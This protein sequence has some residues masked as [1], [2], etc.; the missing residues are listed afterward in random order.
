M[1][2]HQLKRTIVGLDF[3]VKRQGAGEFGFV[4]WQGSGQIFSANTF[5]KKQSP[6]GGD[7]FLRKAGAVVGMKIISTTSHFALDMRNL[8]ECEENCLFPGA[9][10]EVL[11]T[12]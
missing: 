12:Y 7:F 6:R 2:F 5:V 4:N 3:F 9:I 10:F 8:R 1:I 11:V